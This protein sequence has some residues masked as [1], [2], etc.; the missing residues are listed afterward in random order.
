MNFANLFHHESDPKYFAAGEVIINVGDH[1]KHMYVLLE[2][3]AEVLVR[4]QV[5]EVEKPGTVFGEMSM[6]GAREA[7]ASVRA[8]TDITVAVVDERRF[9]FLVQQHPTF[10]LELMRLMADRLENMNERISHV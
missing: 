6:I 3:E 5:V 2:G 9:L 10:A 4:D 8:K 1:D 7:R